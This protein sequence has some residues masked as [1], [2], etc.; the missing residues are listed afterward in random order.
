NYHLA[1][2]YIEHT[3]L[4]QAFNR[5]KLKLIG[6]WSQLAAIYFLLYIKTFSLKCVDFTALVVETP[7]F[8]D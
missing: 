2:C 4:I 1:Y 5:F 7:L 8:S 6:I 3:I